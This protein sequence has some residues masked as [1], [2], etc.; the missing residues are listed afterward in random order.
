MNLPLPSILTIHFFSE[1]ITNLLHILMSSLTSEI[2][3]VT[4]V[5][6]VHGTWARGFRAKEKSNVQ[7]WTRAG[8]DFRKY[9]DEN[10]RIPIEFKEFI[11]SGKNSFKARAAAT[12]GKH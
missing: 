2:D 9:L 6:L 5:H 8:S 7:V 3:M 12:L 11:W 10:S 4:I 1:V